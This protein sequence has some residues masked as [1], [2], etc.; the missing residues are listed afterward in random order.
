MG[1]L[2]VTPVV[3]GIVTHSPQIFL[4]PVVSMTIANTSVP[5]VGNGA[6]RVCARPVAPV[7]QPLSGLVCGRFEEVDLA[8]TAEGDDPGVASNAG[9][10]AA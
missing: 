6:M 7:R 8:S 1:R 9:P 10:I 4:A 3:P 2:Q 5:A